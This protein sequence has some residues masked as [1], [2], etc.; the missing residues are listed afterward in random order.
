MDN[1]S[2]GIVDSVNASTVNGGAPVAIAPVEQDD[3]VAVVGKVDIVILA[4]TS[5]P[6]E[7]VVDEEEEEENKPV[8]TEG[9]C[10]DGIAEV[11]C[12]VDETVLVPAAD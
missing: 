11:F 8:A 1:A 10:L 3:T 4:G 7:E 9:C 5:A 12:I 2:A 6:K